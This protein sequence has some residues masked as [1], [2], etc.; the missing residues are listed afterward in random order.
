MAQNLKVDAQVYARLVEAFREAGA[1]VEEPNY[2][3]VSGMTRIGLDTVRKAWYFGW[4]DRGL[5]PIKDQLWARNVLE[6]KKPHDIKPDQES[7]FSSASEAASSQKVVVAP[8]Q[9]TPQVGLEPT[10]ADIERAMGT[11]Q[12]DIGEALLTEHRVLS[13][14]TKAVE[15]AAVSLVNMLA[16]YQQAIKKMEEKI[17]M[18]LDEGAKAV[19]PRATMKSVL[20]LMGMLPKVVAAQKQLMEMRR[21]QV[22]MPQSIAETRNTNDDEGRAARLGRLFGQQGARRGRVIDVPAGPYEGEESVDEVAS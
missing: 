21:L 19:S 17:R 14:T 18:E 10:K 16:H 20:S 12:G 11:L 5:I 8:R 7:G 13:T 1:D 6:A 15:G 4:P 2:S 3:H 22:G 9:I